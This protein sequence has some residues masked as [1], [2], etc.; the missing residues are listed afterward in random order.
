MNRRLRA[1][2]TL[3]LVLTGGI[4]KLGYSAKSD[5]RETKLAITIHVYNYA[6]V[7]PKTLIEAEKI[8]A[9]VFRKAGVETRWLGRNP[10]S[11][12][13]QEDSAEPDPFHSTDIVLHVLS[14]SMTEKFGLRGEKLGFAPGHG[15]NRQDAY[16]FYD[17]AEE[18]AGQHTKARQQEALRRVFRRHADIAEILGHVIAH[19]LGHLLGLESH[20]A[21][22]IMR[23]DWSLADL[24]DAGYGY[25]LF[26]LQQGEIIRAAVST[27]IAEQQVVQRD[28]PEDTAGTGRRPGSLNQS[29]RKILPLVSKATTQAPTESALSASQNRLNGIP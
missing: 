11:D 26:T 10:N 13:K 3:G 27:R 1:W 21:T 4:T 8:A 15:P 5:L 22:G 24:N 19:E 9:G 14:R 20:S 12:K 6:E 29:L 2:F 7:S 23:A 25:V 17:R 16:V 28:R 18:L